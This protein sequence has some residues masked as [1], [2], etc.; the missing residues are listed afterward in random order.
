MKENGP[1]YYR[2]YKLYTVC[3]K[4]LKVM[5]N[6]T[7]SF[8]ETKPKVFPKQYENILYSA[9]CCV[10]IPCTMQYYNIYKATSI[11]TKFK[12]GACAKF[13][14]NTTGTTYIAKQEL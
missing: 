13:L 4:K 14:I 8:S 11:L 5:Q 3:K 12:K 2:H 10:C 7:K 9:N 1:S 6:K